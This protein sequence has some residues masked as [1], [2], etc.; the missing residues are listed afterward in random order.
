MA[1]VLDRPW[2]AL[3]E[4]LERQDADTARALIQ[5]LGVSE[6]ARAALHLEQIEQIQLM[7]LVGAE[8]AASLVEQFPS[9]T[10]ASL[11]EELDA[12]DAAEIIDELDGD[13][14]ADVLTEL[15]DVDAQAI[16][17]EMDPEDRE[18]VS[19]L[20][21]Y[22]DD[23]AG[24]LMTREV[25]KFD[26]EQTVGSVLLSMSRPDED[27]ERYRGQHPYIVTADGK[28]VGVVSL[29]RLLTSRRAER[30]STIMSPVTSVQPNVPISE[31]RDLLEDNP[32]LG[33]PVANEDGLLIGVVSREAVSEAELERAESE[34]QKL[35]GIVNEELRSMPTVLRARRRLSWLTI[36]IGLNIIAASVI[37]LY[38]DTLAAVIALAVFLPI[39]SDMSGCSGNQAVAVSLREL[40]LGAVRP[41]EVWRVWWKE[42]G[43]GLINGL[44][45]GV[46][47]A[48][49]AWAW[50]GNPYIGLVVGVALALNTMIAVSIGGTV[51]LILKQFDVD[52]AV[53]AGPM[54]TTITDMC[55]FF[56][57]LSLATLMMPLLI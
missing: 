29:R 48:L 9:V 34:V 17:A 19:E 22:D 25:F 8:A 31:L 35:Q 53:A 42:I 15:S 10:A 56:L 36:N 40:S 30:L 57:V 24:G 28:L 7:E 47:I 46:L 4:V 26:D 12:E 2:E 45:L 16:L 52:P 21:S 18:S 33:I 3:R 37:A 27:F 43:V 49:A 50:K 23:T 20:M 14:Q 1:E 41:Q 39:V 54:L 11:I 32:F 13:D 44:A 6:A 55:G 38:E 5:E 51:P